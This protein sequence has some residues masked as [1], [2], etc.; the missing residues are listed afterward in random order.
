MKKCNVFSPFLGEDV[1]SD[2]IARSDQEL[3][4]NTVAE[5][6]Q[7]PQKLFNSPHPHRL[8]SAAPE[9]AITLESTALT[10]QD[11][12]CIKLPGL[13]INSCCTW[14][15]QDST[16]LLG[17][18]DT[19]GSVHRTKVDLLS[20]RCSFSRPWTSE[21]KD[22]L[23]ANFS[24]GILAVDRFS[25]LCWLIFR[26][27]VVPVRQEFRPVSFV[28]A[29]N[30]A[31]AVGTNFG[32]FSWWFS[33]V[34]VVSKVEFVLEKVECFSI[35]A[36]FGIL[37]FGTSLGVY[38]CDLESQQISFRCDLKGKLP[39]LVSISDGLGFIVVECDDL[40]LFVFNVNGQLIRESAMER[41][42]VAWKCFTNREG[43]DFLIV[44]ENNGLVRVCELFYLNFSKPLRFDAGRVV[45]LE[46]VE[47]SIIVVTEDNQLT[48]WRMNGI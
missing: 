12:I 9:N 39:V 11:P 35:S 34:T 47:R 42:I 1:W 32:L 7:L 18:I 15:L 5:S 24:G 40:S 43:L 41:E 28:A 20:R 21:L 16:M 46:Y 26:D 44:C 36:S 22:A 31:V 38:I 19:D 48:V 17:L 2:P 29:S 10:F 33:D 13:P 23:L 3:I 6:G 14:D 30:D 27:R 8:I 4:R 45:M 25:G 37:A